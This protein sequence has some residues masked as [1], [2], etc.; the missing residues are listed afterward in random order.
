MEPRTLVDPPPRGR[1]YAATRRVRS[2][3]AT[4]AGRLRLDALAHYLQDVATDDIL[5]AGLPSGGWVCRSTAVTATRWPRRDEDLRLL[6]FAGGLGSRWAERRT[7]VT[8]TGGAA[9]EVAAV[10]VPLDEATGRAAPLTDAFLAVYTE[11]ARGR[12]VSARPRLPGPPPGRAPALLFPLRVADVDAMGHVNNA[13]HWAAVEEVLAARPERPVPTRAELEYRAG[14]DP[15]PPLDVL[16]AP[17]AEG[18]LRL[19]IGR[20]GTLLASALVA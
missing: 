16:V 7:S 2:A 12:V 9:L 8:G 20:G 5:D 11:A 10:W 1:T 15:G 3:D 13:V 6:T 18:P 17:D 19:W 4:P 14:V